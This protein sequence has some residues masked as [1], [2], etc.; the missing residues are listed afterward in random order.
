MAQRLDLDHGLDKV[1]RDIARHF[2]KCADE[3]H[4][5]RVILQAGLGNRNI[6]Y[7]RIKIMP[8]TIVVGATATAH[9]TATKSDGTVFPITSADTVTLMAATPAD[10]TFGAPVF[11]A[12]GSV[13]IPVIGVSADAGDAVSAS[14]DGVTSAT[15]DTLIIT[16]PVPAAV[17]ITLQ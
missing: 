13:D 17:T 10:V 8:K 9:V 11:N 5:I 14:V 6:A 1:F 4:R 2:E 12:D 16:A 3:L 7:V 15:P